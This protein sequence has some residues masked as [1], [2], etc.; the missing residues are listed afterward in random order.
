MTEKY[1]NLWDEK[2]NLECDSGEPV[3]QEISGRS[4]SAKQDDTAGTL[5]CFRIATASKRFMNY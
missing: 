4:H 3:Y 2:G 5:F 1:K